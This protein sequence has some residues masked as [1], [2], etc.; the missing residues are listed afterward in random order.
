MPRPPLILSTAVVAVLALAGCSSIGT[1]DIAA[2]TAQAGAI[3][4][5]TTGS[6]FFTDS[7]HTVGVEWDEADYDAMIEAYGV[8]ESKEWIHATITIDGAVFEDVG[9]RLK[10]NSTLR[11]L[12]GTGGA[13]G[14]G[15]TSADVSADDPQTLPLLIDFDKYVDGQDFDGLTQL[16]IRP[17]SPVVNEALALSLTAASGQ[18]SQR[19]AYTIYSV[20][21]SATE[22]RLVIENPDEDY[23]DALFDTSGVLFKADADS[24]FTYQGDDLATYEDQFKQLNAEDEAD[25]QP[26]VDFLE[27]MEGASDEEFDAGLADRVDVESF[28]RYAATMNLL[29]NGDDMA[30]PGHNYYLRY[31]LDTG[32]ISVIS[33]DLNGAMTG[34]ATL[35]ADEQPSI[36]GMGGQGGRGGMGGGMNGYGE[37]GMGP[38]GRPGAGPS[39]NGAG[40]QPPSADTAVAEQDGS[41]P[42]GGGLIDPGTVQDQAA[43]DSG[44]AGG[45]MG[46]TGRMGG[47]LLKERFLASDAFAEAYD[48]AYADLYGQMYGD[49]TASGLLEDIASSIPT[50]D[51]LTQEEID[52]QVDTLSA[53]VEERTD[54]LADQAD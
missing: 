14:A 5:L 12:Q 51:A 6:S 53:F 54:A 30:G 33:W 41:S 49:G 17:G 34:D 24:S 8:D 21:G 2:R 50:S 47:N 1:A 31:D 43:P 48:S 11:G 15:G 40:I 27:W 13:G 25:F 4:V 42:P 16:A 39:G 7:P 18:A 10:G 26:I 20:N 29:V 37:G 19:Y 38:G 32:K 23:A 22:T 9:V 3:T 36:G 44:G 35:S 46:G 52:Q 28:A 45:G